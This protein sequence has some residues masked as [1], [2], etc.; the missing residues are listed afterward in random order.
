MQQWLH[1]H[2]TKSEHLMTL[3]GGCT[4]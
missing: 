2:C 3:D 4:V 1:S